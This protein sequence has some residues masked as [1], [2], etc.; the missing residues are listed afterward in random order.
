MDFL[1][2]GARGSDRFLDLTGARF[3]AAEDHPD[4]VAR[5]LEANRRA[6]PPP[7]TLPGWVLADLYLMPAAIGML[8]EGEEIV[9]AHVSVPTLESGVVFGV[10]LFSRRPGQGLA[11]RVKRL[12][13]AAL[14][15]RA[16]RGVTQFDNPAVATHARIGPMRIEGPAPAVHDAPGSFVYRIDLVTRPALGPVRTMPSQELLARVGDGEAWWLVGRGMQVAGPR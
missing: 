1:A 15:A 9:A 13:L 10:S 3:L 14:Q 12:T 11:E 4:W 5:Y 6:F 8:V 16:Q 2:L 7:L